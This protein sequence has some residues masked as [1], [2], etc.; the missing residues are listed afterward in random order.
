MRSELNEKMS[1]CCSLFLVNTYTG[2]SQEEIF[3]RILF[4]HNFLSGMDL[5][6]KIQDEY[7]SAKGFNEYYSI[8]YRSI[9]PINVGIGFLIRYNRKNEITDTITSLNIDKDTK[10]S[11]LNMLGVIGIMLAI[12]LASVKDILERLKIESNS[13]TEI[14]IY[15]DIISID[16]ITL[17]LDIK[18]ETTYD[19][20]AITKIYDYCKG[21]TFS[22]SFKVFVDA[23]TNADFSI[24]YKADGTI[25]SKCAYLISVIKKFVY[26]KDWYKNAAHSINTEPTRCSGMKVPPDWKDDLQM[27]SKSVTPY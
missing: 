16:E 11:I 20:L 13:N 7:Q 1:C 3:E 10:S 9:Y 25:T 19:V 12:E 2:L 8:W 6:D 17:S 15:Q 18:K 14:N 22:V 23:V 21:N 24:V 26:S 5:K 4:A 27:I